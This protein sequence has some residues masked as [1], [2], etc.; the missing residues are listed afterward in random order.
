VVVY[1]YANNSAD[2]WQRIRGRLERTRNLRVVHVV[3]SSALASLAERSM[4]LHCMIQDGQ[5]WVSSG[6]STVQLELVELD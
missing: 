1:C 4:K 3:N 2:W 5:V 6:D